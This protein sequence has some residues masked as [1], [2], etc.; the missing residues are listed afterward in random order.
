MAFQNK[1]CN[2]LVILKHMFLKLNFE[3]RVIEMKIGV[4][5]N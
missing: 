1:R 5:V 3:K 4:S 2:T